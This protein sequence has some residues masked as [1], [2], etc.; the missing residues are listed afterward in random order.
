MLDYK[1]TKLLKN[2]GFPQT[3]ESDTFYVFDILPPF[4]SIEIEKIREKA[5]EQ[6]KQFLEEKMQYIPTLSEI[7]KELGTD[8]VSLERLYPPDE[9]GMFWAKSNKGYE[10]IGENPELACANLY[11]AIHKK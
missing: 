7:I 6:G 1:T 4:N 11:L 3:G 2:A 8:F 10:N 5:S 9:E